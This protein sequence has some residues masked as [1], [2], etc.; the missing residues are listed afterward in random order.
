MSDLSWTTTLAS[1]TILTYI[2]A[3]WQI[4][5]IRSKQPPYNSG[6]DDSKTIQRHARRARALSI[7]STAL[8]IIFPYNMGESDPLNQALIRN[9]CVFYS[10]KILDLAF[11]K[12]QKAPT[13]LLDRGRGKP[14][15]MK[16]F[17]DKSRYVWAMLT[18]MRYHSFDISVNQKGRK[19]PQAYNYSRASLIPFVCIPTI[20]YLFPLA[21]FKAACLLLFLWIALEALHLIMHPFCPWPEFYQPFSAKTAGEFWS[22]HWHAGAYSWQQSLLYRPVRKVTGSPA[23]GILA[24]STMTGIWHGWAAAP[25]SEKP[26]SLGLQGFG[27]FI[28]FGVSCLA[29]RIIW[30]KQGGII[31]RISV[32]AF[33]LLAAGSC[34]NTLECYSRVP[35][36][37]NSQS[38]HRYFL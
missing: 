5:V 12:T 29:E 9:M 35:L 14:A 20:T 26:W 33:A 2:A 34:F 32:W 37:K 22:T 30:K 19:L 18:E 10:L 13:R 27:L 17:Q 11:T 1:A 24:V 8:A 15:T 38:C 6:A 36:L 21:P 16:T 3:I 4:A 25:T 7:I 23:M 28:L 31:Q